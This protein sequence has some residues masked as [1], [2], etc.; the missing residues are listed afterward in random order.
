ME[1]YIPNY[2]IFPIFIINIIGT[3]VLWFL[4]PAISKWYSERWW[5]DP[6]CGV[7]GLL[8]WDLDKMINVS[9]FWMFCLP[10]YIKDI[11]RA[12]KARYKHSV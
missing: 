9:I 7:E 10:F 6:A 2:I 4:L 1:I 11:H 8:T 5:T 3:I 12:I